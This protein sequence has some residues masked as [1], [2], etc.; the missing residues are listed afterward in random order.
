M[1]REV[2]KGRVVDLRVERVT[3]PNGVAVDLELLHHVGASAVVAVDERGRVV[4]IRQYRHAAGGYLWEVPAGI[5]ASPTEPPEACAARELHEEAGVTARELMHLGAIYPTP[6]YSDERIHLFLA[7]GLERGALGHEADEV[8][9]EIAWRPLA[10]V[11]AMIR[12]GEI[13]DGKT[14]CAL[15]L[16]AAALGAS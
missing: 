13:V 3:L 6:G 2:Y 10:D 7:R 4:L 16:A 9:A 11:L 12:R 15:H 1:A 8:I 5:L 14:I